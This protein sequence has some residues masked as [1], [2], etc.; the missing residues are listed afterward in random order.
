[1]TLCT[2]RRFNAAAG[3]ASLLAAGASVPRK[4]AASPGAGAVAG[5]RFNAGLQALEHASGGRLGVHVLDSG[6]G[7]QYGQ[8]GDERFLMCSTFKLMACARL[9]QGV[10]RGQLKLQRRVR[11]AKADLVE[12]SPVTK[13]RVGGTGM[14]L[15]ELCAATLATSDNTAANLILASYGGPA[16]LT[17]FAREIGDTVTR[18]D[19]IEPALNE[20][21]EGDERDTASP[22]ATAHGLRRVL[23]G[24]TLSPAS[25]EQLLRWMRASETG[26]R[27]L[28]AG[29]APGWTMAGKTGTSGE[30]HTNDIAIVWPP[31]RA[32]LLVAGYLFAPRLTAAAREAT[33][34]QVGS[35]L[36]T[37]AA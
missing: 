9:L 20:A 15:G 12:W 37:L 6:S 24:D 34:A 29:L 14:S 36:A 8:R 2:R 25:R 18:Y 31:Q 17:A 28:K 35:L 30:G 33:L 1:M 4:A 22:R 3:A 26:E 23:L 5:D 16:A 13:R 21:T 10:D 7:A 27:R 11:F 32:P 19:R